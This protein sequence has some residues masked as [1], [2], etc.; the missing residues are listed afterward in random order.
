[1][2]E[3][4]NAGTGKLVVLLEENRNPDSLELA[5]QIHSW[6]SANPQRAPNFSQSMYLTM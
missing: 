3:W 5:L 2:H 6:L 4:T 1:M